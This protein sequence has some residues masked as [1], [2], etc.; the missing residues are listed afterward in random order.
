VEQV[1]GLEPGLGADATP[2]LTG[3]TVFFVGTATVILRCAGF[4]IL[5]DPNFL[6]QGEP[7]HLGYGLHSTRRTEPAISFDQLPP[8]DLV[9]LSHLHEDHFDREVARRLRKDVPIITTRHAARSLWR[10]GFQRPTGL[11]AWEALTVVRGGA[12][13]R[14]TSMPGRHAPGPFRFLL[15]PVMGSLLEF[16]EGVAMDPLYRIYVSGDTLVHD[17]LKLIPQR[18]PGIDL[19][20]LHLGGT[21]IVGLMVTMDGAQGVRALELIAPDLAIP[22][23][24]DDYDVFKSPLAD[25][26]AEVR[27]A[28]FERKVRYLARGET[29]SFEITRARRAAA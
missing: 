26:Q 17:E 20:L 10:Q 13:V 6:H 2:D 23:H 19:A 21:R 11:E 24:Y 9:V 18:F 1:L 28:G 15:P 27:R 25:F 14:V 22:I 7:V 5:T 12:R 16:A 29:Y 3:G 4:T 8:I